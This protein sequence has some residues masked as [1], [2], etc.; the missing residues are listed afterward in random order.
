[1]KKTI[2]YCDFCKREFTNPDIN[3]IGFEYGSGSTGEYLTQRHYTS[4]E[5]HWCKQCFK[6]IFNFVT[7]AVTVDKI[8]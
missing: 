4:V 1:M 3:L 7:K 6:L 8:I 2:Y 5:R